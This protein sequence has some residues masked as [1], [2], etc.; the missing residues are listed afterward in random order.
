MDDSK[1]IG[2]FN[3]RS[4]QAIAELSAKYGKI[5]MRISENIL[6]NKEDAEECVNDAYLALWN[7][8]P[9][10]NPSPLLTYLLKTV[11]N[12]SLK[13][14][15]S[16]TALKRNSHYD[17]ALDEL[18][19][20][21]SSHKSIDNEFDKRV[22]VEAINTFLLSCEKTDRIIFIR[23]Y[24]FGDCISDIG[25]LLNKKPHFISVRLSRVRKKLNEYLI[26]EELI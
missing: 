20:I 16:N 6:N 8:I 1:I 18:E 12:R 2:L 21:L 7:N 22:L 25:E 23:R 5:S 17:A 14:Y 26:K 4:Q 24:Y 9:P 3:E 19:E 10:E 13:K 15:H 11:R